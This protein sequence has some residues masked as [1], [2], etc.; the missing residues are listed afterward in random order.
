MN[1][2]LLVYTDASF[3]SK[4]EAF[5]YLVNMG[6]TD[7][8]DQAIGSIVLVTPA[9]P[10]AGFGIA[11]QMAFY[12]LQ[13]AM[14]NVGFSIRGEDGSVSYADN[15]YYG[16]VTYR[17]LIG[18]SGGATF[19][20]D[21]VAGTMDY[22]S[23]I[24]GLLLV[25]GSMSHIS[26]VA[27]FVPTY[28]VNPADATVEKYKSVNEVDAWG[29][30]GDVEYYYNQAQ[31]LQK[32]FVEKAEEVDL[33]AVVS[34]AYY[35]MFINALRVPIIQPNL[36][37][38]STE[39]AGYNWNAAPYS[40]GEH[41]AIIDGVTVDG[42]NVVEHQ[43]DRFKDIVNESGEYLDTWYEL[44]PDEAL[45]NT[46]P[47]GTVPLILANHGGGDDP[48]Q[49]LDEI[50]MMNLV[51][52]KRFAVVAP[53]HSNPRGLLSE[54]L[55][56]LVEYMLDT[57]PALD[58]SRVYVTGYS[59]GGRASLA[60][61]YGDA[62][63]FAA[64][65]PQGTVT[66]LGTEEQDAQ[67]QDIDIPIMF[68]TSTYDFHMDEPTLTLRISYYFGMKSISFDYTTLINKYLEFNEMEPV[69]FDFETYPMSGFKGD[70]Y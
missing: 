52:E 57:Y 25:D 53:Y 51:G 49:Y 15:A 45:N 37:T 43:E 58:A 56:K 1:T 16:G 21:Y 5:D 61:L 65:V 34:S 12:Q 14:C 68:M 2:N 8:A 36:Y 3:A 30:D 48:L 19:I 35:D 44:L 4:S 24:A 67:Y 50:G 63:L 29:I 39:Y 32:V 26:E 62:S 22:I 54:V 40:L 55:P 64:A 6:L 31:P 18:I 46:A 42:I 60:T 47:A 7:I 38:A 70:T 27:T 13:S 11:D 17:Y 9:D 59:M 20:N 66:Y 28:L 10:E 69:A 23:R 41:N 33:K